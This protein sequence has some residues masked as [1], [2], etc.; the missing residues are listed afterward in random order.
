MTI[1]GSSLC[2]DLETS[3]LFIKHAL[4]ETKLRIDSRKNHNA[5]GKPLN[6]FVFI[7]CIDLYSQPSYLT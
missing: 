2:K 4:F 6:H 3:M 5:F 7:R 1:L